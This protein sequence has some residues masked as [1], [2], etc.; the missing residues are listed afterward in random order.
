MSRKI[1]QRSKP[2]R[3]YKT[4]CG[5][6]EDEWTS[7]APWKCKCG[8]CGSEEIRWQVATLVPVRRAY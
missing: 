3:I 6:C 7:K 2:R 5:A 1:K 8:L 4:Y